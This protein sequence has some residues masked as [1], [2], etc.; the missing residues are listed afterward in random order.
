MSAR[1]TDVDK[2][3]IIAGV[4]HKRCSTCGVFKPVV[5]FSGRKASKDGLAYSCKECERATSQKSYKKKQQKNRARTRYM[6]NRE[7]NIEKAKVRYEN[8]KDEILAQQAQWRQSDAG[9]QVVNAAAARRAQRIKEQTPNGR[10]YTR[11]DII[12]RDSVA[13]QCICQICGKP[14]LDLELDLQIDHI[15]PIAA[16]GSDTLENVRC[17]HKIC[18]LKRPKDGKDLS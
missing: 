4:Q 2:Y 9:R 8:R 5:E 1:L 11:E 6:E 13:G 14:I 18:N 16:G 12:K 10:D 7:E 3:K 17:T 15:V